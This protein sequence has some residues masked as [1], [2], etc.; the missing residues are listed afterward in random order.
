MKDARRVLVIFGLC[1]LS[2]GCTTWQPVGSDAHVETS[3]KYTFQAPTGWYLTPYKL[4]GG[5]RVFTRDGT[6]LQ[7]IVSGRS[8]HKRA[9]PAI[10]KESSPDML[11]Q[12]LAETYIA[13]LKARFQN[14]TVDVLDNVPAVLGGS[15][16]V[17]LTFEYRNDAG[18][19]YRAVHYV[20]SA[21]GGLYVL[22]YEA[23]TLHYFERHVAEFEGAV[24]TFRML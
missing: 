22:S 18:L 23:P 8:S 20:A 3:Q 9:F 24:D 2:C 19:R 21:P 13:N 4:A 15:P 7:T 12:D 16:G 10:E 14:D 11:P 17:R 5:A 6:P 1:A